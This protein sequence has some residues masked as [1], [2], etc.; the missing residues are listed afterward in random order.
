MVTFFFLSN[1]LLKRGKCEIGNIKKVLS[2][3]FYFLFI[4]D[5]LVHG[6]KNTLNIGMNDKNRIISFNDFLSLWI[7]SF[8]NPDEIEDCREKS[9]SLTISVYS[10]NDFFTDM[11]TII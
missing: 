6:T 11:F 5:K 7:S 4:L 2:R 8:Y 1:N 3:V 9:Y 10:I